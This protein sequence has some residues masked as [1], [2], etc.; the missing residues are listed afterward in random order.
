[1][2]GTVVVRCQNRSSGTV[3]RGEA[4]KIAAL[5]PRSSGIAVKSSGLL[6]FRGE[7][8]GLIPAVWQISQFG[9][10]ES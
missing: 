4:A 5:V 6:P 10:R 3:P 2:W 1:M 8:R 9:T 7:I